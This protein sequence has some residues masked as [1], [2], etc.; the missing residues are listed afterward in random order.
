MP[1]T[2]R[3]SFVTI[4]AFCEPND[5]IKLWEKF[6]IPM[7]EDYSQLNISP[8]D[9]TNKELQHLASMFESM[10]KKYKSISFSE[11]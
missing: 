3:R 2:L 11:L 9:V 1:Y 6:H 7:F 5:P 8:F 10:R 4:L